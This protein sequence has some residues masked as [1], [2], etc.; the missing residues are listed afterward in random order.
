MVKSIIWAMLVLAPTALV[1][2]P[3]TNANIVQLTG[4]GVGDEA[5]IAKIR[6]SEQV[7]DTSVQQMIELKRSGVSGSVIAAMI[8]AGHP[9]APAMSVDSADPLSPHPAGVY[10]LVKGAAARMQRLDATVTNQAKTGGIWGYA[11][12]GGIA[13]ASIKA[14]IQNETARISVDEA[15]PVFFFFFDESNPEASRQALAWASGTA[16][17]VTS[18]SEFTLIRLNK[19]EGRRE[20]RVGSI[21]IGGSK[22]GVMDSDRLAFQYDLVR[23]GVYRVTPRDPL[24]PGEYGFIYSMSGGGAAGAL[25]ARIFDFSVRQDVRPQS[26]SSN[27]VM[28]LPA[29][30]ALPVTSRSPPIVKAQWRQA[31]YSPGLSVAFIDA[32]SVQR[33]AQTVRF[34]EMLYY[35][36]GDGTDHFTAMRE[37]SCADRS[38]QNTSVTYYSGKTVVR[39]VG[40]S[41]ERVQPKP[42]TV[43]DEVILTACGSRKLGKLFE[44]PA[45]AADLFFAVAKS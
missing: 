37:A 34:S 33:E 35:R 29:V 17:T 27:I 30:V 5:I 14:A 10:L 25:A 28:P 22:T 8:D 3:L 15:F 39:V 40:S 6:A 16:A 24:N 7:F 44:D 36:P 2:E 23:P 43:D 26:V 18:P 38:F 13:S 45:N 19:K 42:G 11:L 12:T 9:K 32:A 41:P 21:N 4:L 20:A 31:S 1:A